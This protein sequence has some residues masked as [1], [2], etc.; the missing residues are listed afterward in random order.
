[1]VAVWY[2]CMCLLLF[3][4][5]AVATEPSSPVCPAY[6]CSGAIMCGEACRR[7]Y[8]P[9]FQTQ[10]VAALTGA[11]CCQ[12]SRACAEPAASSTIISVT[13]MKLYCSHCTVLAG[14]ASWALGAQQYRVQ[15]SQCCAAAG[16]ASNSRPHSYAP[17][18]SLQKHPNLR[19]P[20]LN[21]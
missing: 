19:P 14:R 8:A 7:P 3:A 11:G 2:N 15:H 17:I 10:H 4:A 20:S 13:Y 5:G 18:C 16:S 1:V 21:F 9:T 12:Y 6:R